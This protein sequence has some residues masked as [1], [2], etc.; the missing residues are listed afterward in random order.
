MNLAIFLISLSCGVLSLLAILRFLMQMT[1]VNFY[2]KLVQITCTIT[3]VYCSPL[4]KI[5]PYNQYVD[6]AAILMAVVMQLLGIYL[7]YF[8][9]AAA[10]IPN[11][12]TVISW[13]LLIVVGLSLRIYF[14]TLLLSVVF[15]WVRPA[16]ARPA[17][18]L[19][20]QLIEP[21]LRPLHRLVPP[22][23]GLDFTP[24]ALFFLVYLLQSVWRGLAISMEV[25]LGIIFGV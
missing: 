22:M 9:F 13:A 4:R 25:P 8:L 5:L 3:D 1:R 7:V 16:G 17:A 24:M 11:F 14:M 6:F 20:N 12:S 19:A 18:E 2:N 10:Q 21:F 23:A 15:S